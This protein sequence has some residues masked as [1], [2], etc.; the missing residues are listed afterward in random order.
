MG[1]IL[2]KYAKKLAVAPTRPRARLAHNVMVNPLRN[3][4]PCFW[5]RRFGM[6]NAVQ[7]R[8]SR[9]NLHLA[10]PHIMELLIR[11]HHGA[12]ALTANMAYFKF[13]HLPLKWRVSLQTQPYKRS[14]LYIE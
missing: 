3:K 4:Q 7:R 5:D 2:I 9:E 11:S 10:L 1:R 6:M 14:S 8:T 13:H 12:L